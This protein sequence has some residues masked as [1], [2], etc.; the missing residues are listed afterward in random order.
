MSTMQES[1]NIFDEVIELIKLATI[2]K[3]LTNSV[4]MNEKRK[5]QEKYGLKM[6]DINMIV[7]DQLTMKEI[8]KLLKNKGVHIELEL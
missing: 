6:S 3:S 8:N 2:C 4:L 7:R 5:F 1:I